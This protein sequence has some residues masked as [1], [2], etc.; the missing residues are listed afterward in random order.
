MATL[1]TMHSL[2]QQLDGLAYVCVE[3]EVLMESVY[4]IKMFAVEEKEV[5]VGH[6]NA[7]EAERQQGFHRWHHSQLNHGHK[8]RQFELQFG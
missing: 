6:V 7:I 1:D 5:E 3:C 2:P 8:T 4:C